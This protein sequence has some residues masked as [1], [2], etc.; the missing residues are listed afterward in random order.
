MTATGDH[1][2]GLTLKHSDANPIPRDE[3]GVRCIEYG[4]EGGGKGGAG[5]ARGAVGE[6]FGLSEH[7]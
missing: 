4:V 3:F 2:H 6:G 7:Q 1:V 5:A